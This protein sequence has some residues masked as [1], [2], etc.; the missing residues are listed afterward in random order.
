LVQAL[1][2]VPDAF[3]STLGPDPPRLRAQYVADLWKRLR[4]PRRFLPPAPF[5]PFTFGR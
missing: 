1:A 3:L 2:E 4:A 5:P